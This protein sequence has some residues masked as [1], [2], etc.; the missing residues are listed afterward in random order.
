MQKELEEAANEPKVVHHDKSLLDAPILS[1]S[2]PTQVHT[3][4]VSA[5]NNHEL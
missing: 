2:L 1:S 5:N 4:F 3:R